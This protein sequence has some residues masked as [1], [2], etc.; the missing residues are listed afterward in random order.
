MNRIF[1]GWDKPFLHSLVEFLFNEYRTN[2][3]WDLSQITIVFSS[4]RSI[5]RLLEL[6]AE[7][8]SLEKVMLLPPRGMTIGALPEKLYTSGIPIAGKLFSLLSRAKSLQNSDAQTFQTIFPKISP[9][10]P[11]QE[12]LAASEALNHL[13]SEVSSGGIDFQEAEKILTAG[14]SFFPDQKRWSALASLQETYEEALRENDY[15][16]INSARLTALKSEKKSSVFGKFF[17][18]SIVEIPELI[19]RLILFS[20]A[21]F[22]SLIF[23]PQDEEC[24]FDDFG[25]PIQKIWKDRILPIEISTLNV[26]EKTENQ[27]LEILSILS[28]MTELGRLEQLTSDQ[29]TISLGDEETGTLMEN[30][31]CLSNVPARLSSGRGMIESP[32]SLFLI[33]ISRYLE[34]RDFNSFS[35][36]IRHPGFEK[37]LR[38]KIGLKVGK[39]DV[40]GKQLTELVDRID[41]LIIQKIPEKIDKGQQIFETEIGKLIAKIIEEIDELLDFDR[42]SKLPLPEW[43]PVT[44]T[45]LAK[46]FS[47]LPFEE[48][49]FE[50][51]TIIHEQLEQFSRIS[52]KLNF[53]F[54][55]D[56]CAAVSLLLQLLS[57]E[58]LPAK[59]GEAAIEMV[60]WLETPLDDA[61][62]LFITS[63]NEGLI[64]KNIDFDPFL[65]DSVR[66]I[67][68]LPNNDSRFSRDKANLNAI[69]KSR[70]VY[71]IA[72]RY[73]L[74]GGAL[75]PSRLALSVSDDILAECVQ[76]FFPGSKKMAASDFLKP[77]STS[78]N[79][80][81]VPPFPLNAKKLGNTYSVTEFRDY[82]R[83]P[84]RYYL[85]N[86][87]GLK[88][89]ETR[90]SELDPLCFGIFLH[91]V[92]KN[93]SRSEFADSQ[94]ADEIFVYLKESALRVFHQSFGETVSPIL[95]AQFEIA[96]ER[97]K[98]F[99]S[100]QV[101][102]ASS[103]WRIR[104]DLIEIS[105]KTPFEVD[106]KIVFIKG[107]IDR[108]DEHPSEGFRIFDYK[109]YDECKDPKKVHVQ[110]N[111]FVDLQ[112]P[113]YKLLGEGIGLKGKIDLAYFCLPGKFDENP[114]KIANWSDADLERAFEQAEKV[115]RNIENG[116]FWPPKA[117]ILGDEFSDL[118]LE[119]CLDWSVRQKTAEIR[120][121]SE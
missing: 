68:G 97:L 77:I 109:T 72:A 18:A 25:C 93:F 59:S 45:L 99:S 70:D 74:K 101:E 31:F 1:L 85:K 43:V 115:V 52:G 94:N 67:L 108:I 118:V 2:Y 80:S 62:L 10:A 66:K 119:K 112:L 23:A 69:L 3:E 104:K 78:Q 113:L 48:S 26:V 92:L 76:K 56:F 19:R 34:K 71:L 82:L 29:I 87:L 15:C 86:I 4:Q 47:E 65:T 30:Y 107:R 95:E 40:V 6:L 114:I 38:K 103:G 96:L 13:H 121:S 35:S 33:A 63:L 60:G 12:I 8:A 17:L 79:I 53:S 91:D 39:D 46:V 117:E 54:E 22:V 81:F 73:G 16:D 106:G 61:P 44:L 11:F 102:L 5:R 27:A 90:I 20:E 9:T 116:I 41:Q 42:N 21:D 55:M 110:S 100:K 7:K 57:N 89:L 84:Y 14:I 36:L 51:F 111:E 58:K 50:A 37:F 32:P 64:P 28:K 24:S 105:H 98:F 120:S 83:C 88:S 75:S 49:S